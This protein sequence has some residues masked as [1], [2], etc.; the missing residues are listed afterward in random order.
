MYSVCF[1][2]SDRRRRSPK[3]LL[4][5]HTSLLMLTFSVEVGSTM[6][7]MVFIMFIIVGSFGTVDEVE[8]TV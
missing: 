6:V 1:L 3:L 7:F 2:K 4:F 5:I 8:V